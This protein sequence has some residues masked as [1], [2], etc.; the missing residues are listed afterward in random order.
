MQR[1]EHDYYVRREAQA[2]A[3]AARASDASARRAHLAMAARYFELT[4]RDL[5]DPVDTRTIG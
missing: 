5:D 3:Q 2:R 1:V 4:N